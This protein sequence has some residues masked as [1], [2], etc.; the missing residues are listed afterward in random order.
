MNIK[1][2]VKLCVCGGESAASLSNITTASGKKKK[3][4]AQIDM[5][6]ISESA[7]RVRAVRFGV[8]A[9]TRVAERKLFISG[10]DFDHNFGS[11]FS[12]SN[13]LALETVLK[14]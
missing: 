1:N 14:H 10:S 13:I 9:C 4:F 6:I 12:Y 11:S 3:T 7:C 2:I 5:F 8:F